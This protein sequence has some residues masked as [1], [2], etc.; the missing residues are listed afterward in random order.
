[1]KAGKVGI[2]RNHV[3]KDYRDKNEAKQREET[4]LTPGQPKPLA[5]LSLRP[6]GGSDSGRGVL[7]Q[8]T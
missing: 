4:E 8:L 7:L 6:K 1:M 2:W 5:F 3:K